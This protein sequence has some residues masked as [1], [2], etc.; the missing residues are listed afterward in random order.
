MSLKP[1]I[2]LSQKELL[3]SLLG[4]RVGKTSLVKVVVNELPHIYIDARKFEEIRY[5]TLSRLYKELEQ[6]I[7]SFTSL[8]RGIF[9]CL[10]RVK[11]INVGSFGLEFS[12][13]YRERP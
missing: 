3:Q 1:F 12:L 5:L 8:D 10:R 11:G 2:G 4:R 7:N 13:S 9:E 6:A